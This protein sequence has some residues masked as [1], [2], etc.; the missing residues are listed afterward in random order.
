[1]KGLIV[2][3]VQVDFLP[4]GALAVPQ[5][6]KVIPAINELLTLPFHYIAATKDWHPQGHCS[7]AS[8]YHKKVG[9]H[10]LVGGVEQ[11][12]WPD[13]CV[14][15][16]SGSL[17]SPL[18]DTKRLDDIIYK[19]NE[20]DVDSYSTFFNNKHEHETGLNALL[21]K[22]GVDEIYIA[23]LTTEYCVKNSALD[24]LKL[25]YRVYVVLDGCSAINL[26]PQ[27][28]ERALSEMKK[29]G[30]HIVSLEEVKDM[31]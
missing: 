6:D 30:A 17:L 29:A 5:G 7:F 27:D 21:K 28:E 31:I 24:A 8:T 3:D 19:G 11:I 1:M 15:G 23:G 16:T 13:H 14:Q 10:M 12:L 18:L 25:G 22:K 26:D 20:V 2:V 9:E 4:G